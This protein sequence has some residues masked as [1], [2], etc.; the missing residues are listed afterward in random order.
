MIDWTIQLFLDALR[1][2]F[3]LFKTYVT[4]TIT[5]I[6]MVIKKKT[7]FKVREKQFFER[8]DV[9]VW[10][11]SNN[12]EKQTDKNDFAKCITISILFIYYCKY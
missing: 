2:K 11:G 10:S 3:L 5:L 8:T 1:T 12:D 4:F 9:N 6:V 7:D